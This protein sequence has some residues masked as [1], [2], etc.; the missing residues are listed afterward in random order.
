MGVRLSSFRDMY[1]CDIEGEDICI[2]L[3]RSRWD[4]YGLTEALE[5]IGCE[6]QAVVYINL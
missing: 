3:P 1:H 5:S 4:Y 2:R 6:N